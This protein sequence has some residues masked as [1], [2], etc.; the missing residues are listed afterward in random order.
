VASSLFNITLP[1]NNILG[2]PPQTT[3]AIS[4]GTFVMLKELPVGQHAI[5]ASGLLVDFTTTSNLNFVS[6][7][8]SI[9]KTFVSYLCKLKLV[10]WFYYL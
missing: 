9:V 1:E 10:N 5:Y 6:E 4:D 3:E 2:V 7:V 8:K